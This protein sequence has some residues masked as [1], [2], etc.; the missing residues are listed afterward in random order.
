MYVHTYV[1][2]YLLIYCNAT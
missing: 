2:T 1:H